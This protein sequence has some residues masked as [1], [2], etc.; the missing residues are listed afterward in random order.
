MLE[1]VEADV[2]DRLALRFDL[3]SRL[4]CLRKNE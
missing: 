2:G 4:V 1:A 3:E